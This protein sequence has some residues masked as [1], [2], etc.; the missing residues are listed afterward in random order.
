MNKKEVITDALAAKKVEE[1]V[2]LPT[3]KP[4]PEEVDQDPPIAS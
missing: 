3:K 1:D 2:V 4:E